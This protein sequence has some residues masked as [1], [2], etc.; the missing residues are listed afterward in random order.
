MS[1]HDFSRQKF[2]SHHPQSKEFPFNIEIKPLVINFKP[3][4]SYSITPLPAVK[5]TSS[6]LLCL[7]R[8]WEDDISLDASRCGSTSSVLSSCHQRRVVPHFWSSSWSCPGLTPSTSHPSYPECL[9]AG[10]STP[11]EALSEQSRAEGENQPTGHTYF[12]AA[13]DVVSR[14]QVHR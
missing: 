4:T 12:D 11:D 3:T 7:L 13:Q 14:L 5:S 10:Y 9:G 1:I 8:Y 2:Q 6:I